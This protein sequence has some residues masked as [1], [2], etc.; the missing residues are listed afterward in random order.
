MATEVFARFKPLFKQFVTKNLILI[1]YTAED[2]VKIVHFKTGIRADIVCVFFPS[3]DPVEGVLQKTNAVQYETKS[4]SWDISNL[5]KHLNRHLKNPAKSKR[6]NMKDNSFFAEKIT[7]QQDNTNAL[8][9]ESQAQSND[10][11]KITIVDEASN[12]YCQMSAPILRL[13][14]STLLNGENKNLMAIKHAEQFENIAVINVPGDGNCLF[15]ACVHQIKRY[16]VNSTEH[17]DLVYQLRK[18]VVDY[19]SDNLNWFKQSMY[20]NAN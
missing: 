14:E 9:D 17:N 7:E 16:K 4:Q 13:I 18:N 2:V 15:G 12:L 3:N 6:Q 5:K 1:R 8:S 20:Q 10:L 19:I 11:M